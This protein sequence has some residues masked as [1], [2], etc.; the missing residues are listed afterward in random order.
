MIASMS[1]N[2]N[3]HNLCFA[4]KACFCCLD[5]VLLSAR[6][7]SVFFFFFYKLRRL[8]KQTQVNN[9]EYSKVL[10]SLLLMSTS[11]SG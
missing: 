5:D 9:K 3:N 4:V 6:P 10:L 8:L 1:D 2:S 11:L 7:Y